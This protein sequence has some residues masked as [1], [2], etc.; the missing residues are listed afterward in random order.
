[1]P[2]ECKCEGVQNTRDNNNEMSFFS[3]NVLEINWHCFCTKRL[4]MARGHDNVPNQFFDTKREQ[5][6]LFSEDGDHKT[7]TENQHIYTTSKYF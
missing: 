1:M 6:M 2:L 3:L 7:V 4:K 5:Y